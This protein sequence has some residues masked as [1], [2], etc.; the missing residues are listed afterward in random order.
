MSLF[1]PPQIIV[2]M[3]VDSSEACLKLASMLDP[4]QCRLKIGK[5]LFNAAGPA[6]LEKLMKLNFTIF[7]DLKYHDIPNTV[8]NAVGIAAELGVWMVNVHVS[9]GLRMLTAAKEM[10]LKRSGNCP[11]LIGVTVLT[12]LDQDDLHSVGVECPLGEQVMRLAVL[13]QHA[14][15]DGVVCSAIEVK[16]LRE[17]F[18]QDFCLV[19]PG[20]RPLESTADDQQRIASP[21]EAIKSG[22]DYLVIGR[23]IISA[24]DPAKV[25]TSIVNSISTVDSGV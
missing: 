23:P 12:S 18:G 11:L 15:L 14:G 17:Q 19:T 13:A 10:L 3:D 4:D 7:L 16:P 6:L 9:G 20:I 2:A 25:L 24:G 5:A 1:S 8:A 22:S 21:L